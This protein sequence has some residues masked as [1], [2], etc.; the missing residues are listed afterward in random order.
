MESK[1]YINQRHN[2]LYFSYMVDIFQINN[3]FA[4]G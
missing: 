2:V 4:L 3:D 1:H